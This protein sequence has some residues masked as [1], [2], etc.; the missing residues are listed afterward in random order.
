M[1]K[2]ISVYDFE[3]DESA[4][5]TILYPTNTKINISSIMRIE[6][7]FIL[8]MFWMKSIIVRQQMILKGN[9]NLLLPTMESNLLLVMT[10]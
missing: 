9:S 4:N 7:I 3:I 1:K 2:F 6:E 5:M 8:I 10:K